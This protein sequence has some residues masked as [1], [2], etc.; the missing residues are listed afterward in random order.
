MLCNVKLRRWI[1]VWIMSHVLLN[2]VH[3]FSLITLTVSVVSVE[4]ARYSRRGKAIRGSRR[5]GTRNLNASPRS[6]VSNRIKHPRSFTPSSRARTR[7]RTIDRDMG[8]WMY[9]PNHLR[10]ELTMFSSVTCRGCISTSGET[11]SGQ[12]HVNWGTICSVMRKG[13]SR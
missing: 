12:N 5:W 6:D 3:P 7:R 4:M 10:D 8:I 2:Q 13:H 1:G 11:L 9:L